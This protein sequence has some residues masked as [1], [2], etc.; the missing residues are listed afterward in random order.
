MRVGIRTER[1]HTDD[2]MTNEKLLEGY[3]S[4][5]AQSAFAALVQRH[6]N[7]VYSTALRHVRSPQLAEE[8]AQSVFIDLARQGGGSRR[9]HRWLLGCTSSVVGLRS[10]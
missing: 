1:R 10:T 8:V 6:L 3:V 7:L 5:S 4:G 9:A 2:E